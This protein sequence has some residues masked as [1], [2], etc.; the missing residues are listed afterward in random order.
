MEIL[1]KLLEEKLNYSLNRLENRN[2]TEQDDLKY[3][4]QEYSKLLKKVCSIKIIN[5]HSKNIHI[6]KKIVN[7]KGLRDLSADNAIHNKSKYN[8][9]TLN[10]SNHNSIKYK[11]NRDLK[12]INIS[13]KHISKSPDITI[14]KKPKIKKG[15]IPSYMKNTAS[16][17]SKHNKKEINSVYNR[18]KKNN[19]IK[20]KYR[21]KTPDIKKYNKKYKINNNKVN[22][23]EE[24]I[25][26]YEIDNVLNNKSKMNSNV[27]NNINE[28]KIKN[29][30]SNTD[31]LKD[32]NTK[33]FIIN[34]RIS[35]N[36]INNL[37]NNMISNGNFNNIL[38]EHGEFIKSN[39][40]K[41]ILFLISS[42]LDIKSKVCYFLMIKK[43]IPYAI[44]CIKELFQ[45]FNKINNISESEQ[46]SDKI[47]KIKLKYSN[48]QLNTEKKFEISLSASRALELLNE[49]LYKK[50]FKE[51]LISP[52]NEIL[53][54]YRIFFI[55]LNEKEIINITDDIEFFKKISDYFLNKNSEYKLG[56]L[57]KDKIE[58]FDLSPQNIF[59]IKK[60]IKNHE[61]KLNRTYYSKICGTTSLV[62]FLIKE[63]LEFCGI[64]E[65]DKKNNPYILLKYY[66]YCQNAENKVNQIIEDLKLKECEEI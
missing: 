42:F 58:L 39:I 3:C 38:F 34:T 25:S 9:K 12:S 6:I 66:E 54:I 59:K 13:K 61:E 64:I 51:K 53:I 50:I 11:T 24:N 4:N 28:K 23:E 32:V 56:N 21:A 36:N 47:R 43:F 35:E 37:E 14:H 33:D 8:S 45:N 52:K 10:T 44:P 22:N 2:K 60:L 40:Y 19:E 65:D 41:D 62:V 63:I 57:F 18:Y 15:E 20:E 49:N 27:S 48:E 1:K 7:K 5:P 31:F 30:I 16:N 46:I 55:L 29:Q 17:E 26:S